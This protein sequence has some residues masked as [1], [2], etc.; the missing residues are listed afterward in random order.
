MALFSYNN[1]IFSPSGKQ[2]I[3]P[4]TSADAGKVLS[5]D[6]NGDWGAVA[7]SGGG[8]SV[9][10]VPFKLRSTPPSN[11]QSNFYADLQTSDYDGDFSSVKEKAAAG[12][13]ILI[14]LYDKDLYGLCVFPVRL[15]SN[16]R[17][18]ANIVEG[19]EGTTSEGGTGKYINYDLFLWASSTYAQLWNL[20]YIKLSEH[21]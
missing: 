1:G 4:V 16:N 3:P 17:F 15:S 13:K 7:A 6:D 2:I 12:T 9:E 14:A 18:Y 11:V 10:V 19:W 21:S 5:V 8:G 20:G